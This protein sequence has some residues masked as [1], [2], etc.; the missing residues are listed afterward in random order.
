MTL[1]LLLKKPR[2]LEKKRR[3]L[4]ASKSKQVPLQVVEDV[5]FALVEKPLVV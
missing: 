5:V 2:S 4:V 3:K 1:H